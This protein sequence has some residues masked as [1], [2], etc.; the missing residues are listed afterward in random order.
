MLSE[1]INDEELSVFHRDFRESEARHYTIS[2]TYGI[3]YGVGIDVETRW[4]EWL[5]FEESLLLIMTKTKQFTV[6]KYF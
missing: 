3:K 4:R 5:E 6:R 2:I 1:N